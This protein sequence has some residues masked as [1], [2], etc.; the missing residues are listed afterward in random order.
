MELHRHFDMRTTYQS[1][2]SIVRSSGI[3]NAR[4]TNNSKH[5]VNECKT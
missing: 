5:L 3:P 1:I 4:T 2:L